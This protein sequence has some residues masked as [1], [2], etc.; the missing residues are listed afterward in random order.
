MGSSSAELAPG[1][2]SN[3]LGV[4]GGNGGATVR[5]ENCTAATP[6]EPIVTVTADDDHADTLPGANDTAN[7]ASAYVTGYSDDAS[8]GAHVAIFSVTTFNAIPTTNTLVN[9]DFS[10]TVNC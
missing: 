3:V 1:S 5:V 8:P 4:S 9:T 7:Y 6:T 2:G 10:F